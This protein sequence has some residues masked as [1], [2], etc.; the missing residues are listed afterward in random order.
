MIE[1]EKCVL[2]YGYDRDG[3]N[4]RYHNCDSQKAALKRAKAVRADW[5]K[6]IRECD[7]LVLANKQ[8]WLGMTTRQVNRFVKEAEGRGH[9]VYFQFGSMPIRIIRAERGFLVS[10]RG[11]RYYNSSDLHIYEN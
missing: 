9:Y 8:R 6:V 2:A 11:D 3:G 5:F 1:N 4:I 10:I 7:G